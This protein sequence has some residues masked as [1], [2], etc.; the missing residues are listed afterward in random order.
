MGVG[1]SDAHGS[2]Q[3]TGLE[4]VKL[5]FGINEF[6]IVGP[7]RPRYAYWK[8]LKSN[9]IPVECLSFDPVVEKF[10]NIETDWFKHFFPDARCVWSYVC[11]VIDSKGELKLCGLKKKLFEQI[12]SAARTL[13]DPTDNE[14]GWPIIFEKKKT[15]PNKFNVEYLLDVLACK[16]QQR[17]LTEEELEL[18]ATLKPID[19][20]VPRMTA[21]QQ[22]A[23]IESAWLNIEEDNADKEAVDELS[24]AKLASDEAKV[25]AALMADDVPV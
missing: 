8:D 20:M 24:G 12:Q 3:K 17:P 23:F 11:T 14:D 18:V 7:L 1:F 22:K 15:G 9:I 25:A 4:Y 5:E 16:D 6:R 10:T 13:D 19:E 21:D 2:A